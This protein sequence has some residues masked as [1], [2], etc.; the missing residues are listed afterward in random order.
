M[1]ILAPVRRSLG[2]R[3]G[4]AGAPDVALQERMNPSLRNSQYLH[5]LDLR[6]AVAQFAT[7][8]PLTILDYG[9]GGAPYRSLFPSS[10]YRCADFAGGTGLHYEYDSRALIDEAAETFDLILSTQ[11]LEHVPDPASY[12]REARRLLKP[13]G[14]LLLTVPMLYWEHGVPRDYHR[15]TALGLRQLLTEAGFE[16]KELNK[17]SCNSR[18]ALF[19]ALH[20]L[21]R[22]VRSGGSLKPAALALSVINWV[23]RVFVAEFHRY[24][25]TNLS[26]DALCREDESSKAL[27]LALL[28]VAVRSE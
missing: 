7:D 13:K 2:C 27:Y 15:W 8:A 28:A 11:V 19:L 20:I 9:C 4:S 24:A 16:V 26:E 12:L 6:D 3:R 10:D 1:N 17:L 5:L 18:A 22:Y 23:L 14:R 25:E 21:P